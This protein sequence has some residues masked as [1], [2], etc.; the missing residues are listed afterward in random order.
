MPSDPSSATKASLDASARYIEEKKVYELFEGLMAD[1]LIKKPND[2]IAHM[3]ASLKQPPRP[4]VFV[5]G[6]PGA[7]TQSQ[8]ELISSK[9]GLVHVVPKAVWRE[10][11]KGGSE[12]GAS[13]KALEDEGKEVPLELKV[14][15]LVEKLESAECKANGWVLDGFP[16]NPDEARA[17]LGAGMLP[18]LAVVLELTDAQAVAALTGRRVD[19]EANNVYHLTDA[20]PPDATVAARL[21]Q[22]PDDEEAAVR[23]RLGV[24]RS[25]IA[26]IAPLIKKVSFVVDGAAPKEAIYEQVAPRVTA[27]MPSRAPRGCPRVLLLG[28]PGVYTADVATGVADAY[29]AKL[30]SARELLVAQGESLIGKKAAGYLKAGQLDK[31]PTDLIGPLVL[32]R[33]GEEDVR[34]HGFVLCGFP[35]TSEQAAWLTKRGVWFRHV[36]LLDLTEEAAVRRLEGTRFDPADGARYHPDETWPS[37]PAVV[38]RLVPPHTKDDANYTVERAVKS[39]ARFAAHALKEWKACAPKLLA[40]FPQLQVEDGAMPTRAIVETLAPCFVLLEQ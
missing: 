18:T 13:A 33:L 1:L 23:R 37:D 32:A 11:A 31:V 24:Y 4:R 38:G 20:P 16:A 25:S 17:L 14:S 2:P 15:M 35:N 19:L 12:A 40:Q 27:E 29:G 28:G 7:D 21:V 22:R 26:G 30:I 10:A 5:F 34:R 8:C 39:N 9:L 6:P 36:A 3:I